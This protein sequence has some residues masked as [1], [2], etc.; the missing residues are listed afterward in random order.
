MLDRTFAALAD[1]T[2]REILERLSLG[3]ATISELARPS[4]ISLPGTLKH[5]RVLEDARLVTTRKRG[6]VRECRLGP[7]RMDDATVWMERYRIRWEQRFDR[8]E[9][10]LQ[11]RRRRERDDVSTPREG[12][13][14]RGG[15][16]T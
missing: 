16:G 11:E 15:S 13:H 9:A 5:V 12:P 4:G 8:L 6:R 1:P 10:H 3:P 2:R 14:G 7:D